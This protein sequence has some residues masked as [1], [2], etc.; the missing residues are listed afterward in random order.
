MNFFAHTRLVFG[1]LVLLPCAASGQGVAMLKEQVFHRDSTATAVPYTRIVDSHGPYLRIV[2]G[3]RNVDVLCS[4]LVDRIEVPVAVPAMIEKE[5]EIEA[6]RKTVREL[7]KFRQRYL[8]SGD[9]LDS[10]ISA[11]RAHVAR[12]E[13]GL[14][15]FE[16]DWITKEAKSSIVDERLLQAQVDE[17]AEIEKRIF[18]AAQRDRGL[19]L[20]MGEWMTKA[21]I[22]GIP[23]TSSTVLSECIAPLVNGDL[24]GAKFAVKNLNDLATSQTGEAK[25]RTQRLSAVV[26]NLFRAEARLVDHMIKGNRQAFQAKKGSENAKEWLKPN[27][28][29][30]VNRNAS[31]LAKQQ[32][33]KLRKSYKQDLAECREE[34][35]AELRGTDIVVED[36]HKLR[37]LRVVLILDAAVRIVAAR[38]FSGSAF[39]PAVPEEILEPIRSAIRD[40]V[41]SAE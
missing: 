23:P 35:L 41:A 21:E 3:D 32:A 31:K 39:K 14:V 26:R 2:S 33:T 19:I 10:R 6:L 11:L 40:S 28:F 12:Y 16:G 17:L 34:L 38:H 29:G 18:A 4:E 36:F 20:Y 22:E 25:V 37:E 27:F 7:E 8:K 30:T 24:A 1:V 9:L 13:E 15:R 5:E